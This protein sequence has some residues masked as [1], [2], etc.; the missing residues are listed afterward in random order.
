MP[1]ILEPTL[2][3]IFLKRVRSTPDLVGFQFKRDGRWR[4][5][6][7]K[8]IH[9]QCRA[10]SLGLIEL[11]VKPS[12]S[13]AILCSTRPEWSIA[14]IAIQ[15]ARA[16]GVPIYPSNTAEDAAYILN[17]SET[18][19][20]I[21]ENAAQLEKINSV[22]SKGGLPLLNHVIVIDAEGMTL[23]ERETLS[24]RHVAE[25]GEKAVASQPVLFEENLEAAQPQ[26]TFTLCYTSG[27]T[28]TPKGVMLSQ[29]NLVSV[30]EDCVRRFSNHVGSEK[31]TVLSFLPFSHILGRAE[32]LATYCFG[33]KQ[34]FAEDTDRLL[35]NF[36]EVKP[37]LIFA[38][39]RVFE[40][41]YARIQ[42]M[43]AQQKPLKRKL[44]LKT[45]A[46]GHRLL[47][48]A[49]A[50]KK[51]PWILEATSQLAQGAAFRAIRKRFG[52]KLKY[53]ICGGAPLSREI[54]EFFKI[55]GIDVLEGYGLTETSAPVAL[56]T[57]D[58][59]RFGSVG[60]PLPEVRVKIA[61]DGEVLIKSRKVFH[62][63]YKQPE[64]TRAAFEG[65][66][67]HTGDIGFLDAQ[68][69]LHITDRKKDLIVTSG[70][71][72]I[73]PQKIE[74][75]AKLHPLISQMVVIGDRRPYLTAL[76]SLDAKLVTEYAEKHQ[77]LHSAYAELIKTPK[78]LYLV[79]AVIDQINAQ[80]ASFETIKKF[81]IIPEEFTIESGELT[82]SLKIKRKAISKHHQSEIERLYASA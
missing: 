22:R 4:T 1:F 65:E 11:G 74:A 28:G 44:A 77:I 23:D 15:G 9:E 56:N 68:Q 8:K 2:N 57:P 81:L 13:V 7:F 24:W 19:I 59:F 30:L 10:L 17:H 29:D 79:Q 42:A 5:L 35:A 55:V 3:R 45:I 46:F 63:Y 54:G 36:S 50:G 21:A 31:E 32:S 69:F 12:H 75:L 76:V 49:Q 52:G 67:F 14:D 80:L 53:A 40:K 62:G 20:L 51:N 41:A 72:N 18:R 48:R 60:K 71:K 43:I 37:T 64:E 38:V 66:W 6:S 73:A 33:W 26:D 78:I 25:L 58:E 61:E 47:D 16:V 34:A 39:P 27:T 82:P 70:G